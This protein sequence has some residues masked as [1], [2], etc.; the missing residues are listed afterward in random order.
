MQIIEARGAPNPRRVRIFVAEKGLDIPYKGIDLLAGEHRQ[1]WFTKLNPYGGVPVLVFDNGE[2]LS[3]TVAICRYLEALY[4]DPPLF[5]SGPLDAA[6]IEMWN[7]RME[8][9]VFGPVAQVFRHTHPRL[10]ALES[11]Q[12][13]EW[14]EV[15]RKRARQGLERLNNQLATSEFVTGSTYTIADITAFVGVAFL[16]PARLPWPEDLEHLN[17]WF[18]AVKARES[19]VQAGI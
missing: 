5:G 18:E 10:A 8:F 11:P 9:S 3:E 2:S 13:P 19:V 6:R 12:L 14:A 15:N 1:D 16:K 4:P 17:R 7:R